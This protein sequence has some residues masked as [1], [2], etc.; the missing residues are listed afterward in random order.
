MTDS[1]TRK[2]MQI[3]LFEVVN[4]SMLSVSNVIKVGMDARSDVSHIGHKNFEQLINIFV[5]KLHSIHTNQGQIHARKKCLVITNEDT[6]SS[7]R[8]NI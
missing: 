3:V 6:V 7:S 5:N 8:Q 1:V 2:F 4:I